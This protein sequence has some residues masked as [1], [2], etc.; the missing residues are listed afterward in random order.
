[1]PLPLI[2]FPRLRPRSG[3]IYAC[4]ISGICP[5]IGLVGAIGHVSGV[6]PLLVRMTMPLWG[7]PQ[8]ATPGEFRNKAGVGYVIPL[9]L[10]PGSSL[11]AHPSH[12]P[13]PG[14]P[15]LPLLDSTAQPCTY[16]G[17]QQ[18]LLWLGS[19]W[20]NLWRGQTSHSLRRV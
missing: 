2:S 13:G 9:M 15:W 11:P 10:F 5:K 18:P 3:S 16:C 8:H 1:M 4:S 14:L 20:A 17:A 19:I 6:P 12:Q 7:T